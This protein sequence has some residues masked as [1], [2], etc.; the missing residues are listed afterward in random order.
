MRIERALLSTAASNSSQPETQDLL[1]SRR[2]AMQRVISAALGI[3]GAVLSVD[4]A[5]RLIKAE[6]LEAD[7]PSM[8]ANSY[9]RAPA[10]PGFDDMAQ[11]RKEQLQT[12]A[13]YIKTG[14]IKEVSGGL[15]VVLSAVVIWRSRGRKLDQQTA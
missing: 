15:A 9:G 5:R 6:Q 13:D 1:I 2:R 7:I 4:G 11:V 8:L 3:G 10:S 14:G 12:D